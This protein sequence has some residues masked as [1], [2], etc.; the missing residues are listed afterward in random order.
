MSLAPVLIPNNLTERIAIKTSHVIF[1]EF[2]LELEMNKGE[3]KRN[4]E[5]E[6]K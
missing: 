2:N 4:K 6:I 5:R 3:E 1:E